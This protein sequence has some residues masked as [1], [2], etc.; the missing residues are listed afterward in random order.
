M[1]TSPACKQSDDI[2]FDLL[3]ILWDGDTLWLH[4]ANASAIKDFFGRTF[5]LMSSA[6]DATQAEQIGL[7]Y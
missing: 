1:R 6:E 2:N 5:T 3:L 4:L 7:L